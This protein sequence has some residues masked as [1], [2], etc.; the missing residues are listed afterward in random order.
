M[1]TTMLTSMPANLLSDAFGAAPIKPSHKRVTSIQSVSTDATLGEDGEISE[2][3]FSD[4]SPR[5]KALMVLFDNSVKDAAPI[6]TKNTFVEMKL[7]RPSEWDTCF[8]DRAVQ[9]APGSVLISPAER[10]DDVSPLAAFDQDQSED[11]EDSDLDEAEYTRVSARGTQ[12]LPFM[13]GMHRAPVMARPAAV[14]LRLAEALEPVS[15]FA[16][17]PT[18]GSAGHAL[19]KCKP[20][21][22]AW[23]E[24]GCQSGAS[25][26]FCHLCDPAE[27]KR[28]RKAKLQLRRNRSMKKA[29]VVL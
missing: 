26:K 25:C 7:P 4:V 3:E 24:S 1:M 29:E 22:F 17:I 14:T 6:T 27:K 12:P 23:K 8:E 5:T 19:R 16:A 13:P 11:E 28:R 21:A 2:T 20:C 10:D 15:G 18:I 9:S